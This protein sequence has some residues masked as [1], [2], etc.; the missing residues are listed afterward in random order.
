M[1]NFA[2]S[3]ATSLAVGAVHASLEQMKAGLEQGL[4][5]N[6]GP[7]TRSNKIFT[8]HILEEY[9]LPY[10]CW[11]HFDAD[12]FNMAGKGKGTPV[13]DWDANCR[14]LAEGYEC[15]ILD[16]QARGE[17]CVPWEVPY[18]SAGFGMSEIA[19]P[20]HCQFSAK[21][22]LCAEHACLVETKFVNTLANFILP[23]APAGFSNLQNVNMTYL[24]S[25]GFESDDCP[26]VL[27][28]RNGDGGGKGGR[29]GEEAKQCCGQHPERFPYKPSVLTCCEATPSTGDGKIY[30]PAMM[31]CCVDGS[32][33]GFGSQC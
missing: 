22:N 16:A 29:P 12:K 13:D 18:E 5:A 7:S 9:F 1:T 6:A 4:A 14:R 23:G 26:V 10:G 8:G 19:V 24:H 28:V 25:A 21:G 31:M 11:C 30:N 32:V 3:I 33:K 17:E 15:A 27:P 20:I 2:K